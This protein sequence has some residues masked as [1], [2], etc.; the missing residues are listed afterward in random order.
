MDFE[1]SHR[2]DGDIV[3]VKIKDCTRRTIYRGKF[4]VYDKNSIL[5]LIG[6]LEKFSGFSVIQLIKEKV[7]IGEW[8]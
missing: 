8:F 2:R 1:Y 6:I 7:K 4:N 3:E 5:T